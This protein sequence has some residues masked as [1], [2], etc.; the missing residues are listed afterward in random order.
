M[1]NDDGTMTLAAL[2]LCADDINVFALARSRARLAH[3]MQER[4]GHNME[5]S[6]AGI[7]LTVRAETNGSAVPGAV[8]SDAGPL[9]FR[10]E[11]ELTP[12][13]RGAKAS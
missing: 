4:F 3:F 5:S 6:V 8:V 2:S 9:R 11:L 10:Y 1:W 13:A 12:A 7:S